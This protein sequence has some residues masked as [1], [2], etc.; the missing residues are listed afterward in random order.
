M[1]IHAWQTDKSPSVY[2]WSI[3]ILQNY[4]PHLLYQSGTLSVWERDIRLILSVRRYSPYLVSWEHFQPFGSHG[5]LPAPIALSNPTTLQHRCRQTSYLS[6]LA[7]FRFVSTWK[8]QP[9]I[10]LAHLLEKSDGQL[11]LK[12]RQ[13]HHGLMLYQWSLSLSKLLALT[14][15]VH[16]LNLAPFS[17]M[18][19]LCL[20]QPTWPLH[21]R[22]YLSWFHLRLQINDQVLWSHL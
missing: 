6:S 4:L 20:T 7:R 13:G 8:L 12:L 9:R 5:R 16:Q 15:H 14:A 19:R 17:S 3:I 1:F 18:H 22:R 10:D 11:G 21:M 2:S